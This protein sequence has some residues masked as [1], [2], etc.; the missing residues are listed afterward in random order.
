MK[1]AQRDRTNGPKTGKLRRDTRAI[2]RVAAGIELLGLACAAA[3]WASGGLTAH[4]PHGNLGWL[5][6]IV[7]CGCLPSGTFFL[8]LGAGKW[9]SDRSR[10]D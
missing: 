6:L 8:L 1:T 2:L 3:V 5:G 4:G 10:T 9:I 7:A